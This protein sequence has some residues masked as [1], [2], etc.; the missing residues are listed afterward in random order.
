[1]RKI[2]SKKYSKNNKG[3][4]L[5]EMIVALGLFS[6]GALIAVGGFISV[7]SASKKTQTTKTSI[8]STNYMM[9][10]ML[11]EMRLG[12]NYFCSNSSG[13]NNYNTYVYSNVTR[14]NSSFYG[15]PSSDATLGF[16][17]NKKVAPAYTDSIAY[18][19]RY[20]RPSDDGLS[21]GYVAKAEC[22]SASTCSALTSDSY[23]RIT[24]ENINIT[25]M[26]FKCGEAVNGGVSDSTNPQYLKIYVK[27]V[28]GDKI[29]EQTEFN[30]ES[31]VTPRI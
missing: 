22:S 1:M 9:E 7:I 25:S 28:S 14:S 23:T 29:K 3:F 18:V 19:Y 15:G 27:G 5:L 26:Y 16:I 30:L 6:V 4:S 13:A 10:G 12:N 17:T 24:P 11:R 21:Y 2:F 20:T 31:L 8:N